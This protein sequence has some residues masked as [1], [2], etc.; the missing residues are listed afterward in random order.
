[1]KTIGLIGQGGSPNLGD[2]A[3]QDAMISGIRR[4]LPDARI[5]LLT[6][7]P[8]AASE[9]HGVESIHVSRPFDAA[10][11]GGPNGER[12]SL[13][14]RVWSRFRTWI[15]NLVLEF[16]F[17]R[18]SRRQLRSFD[19]LIVSGG[20]QM[21]DYWG[22]FRNQPVLFLKWALLSKL[23]GVR[24]AIIS[25]GVGIS[26][27]TSSLLFALSSRLASYVSFR[28]EDSLA[29]A[30]RRRLVRRAVV[31]PDLVYSLSIPEFD[32]EAITSCKVIGISPICNE[33]W[34]TSPGNFDAYLEALAT[35][36]S[37]LA[38]RGY[39]VVFFISQLTMDRSVV[40]E[41]LERIGSD[42]LRAE[43]SFPEF[44]TV[45]GLC[46]TITR[47]DVIVA[48]RLH[49][50]LISHL[51]R[52]P[53]IAASY[54]AKTNSIMTE[55][56]H[57]SICLDAEQLT[58]SDLE[59]SLET[60]ESRYGELVEMIDEQIETRRRKVERQYDELLL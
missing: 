36:A 28:D 52:R 54:S 10:P 19:M 27:R 49:A 21:G 1:M 2:V 23:S 41:I 30:L 56:G 42:S 46:E 14:Y 32:R 39:R 22:G 34:S 58:V 13:V 48:S 5:I 43:M 44:A 12:R 4:R 53:V 45:E 6:S 51:C 26:A 11:S 9:V 18:E 24:F 33:S 16:R 7:D 57:Q 47:C 3:I 25:M 60:V 35:F 40:L 55:M 59:R 15:G 8:A 50:I 29:E 31:V 20:G 17:L 38:E 37:S